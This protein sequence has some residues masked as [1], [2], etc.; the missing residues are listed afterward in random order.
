MDAR[1]DAARVA[2]EK[3]HESIP[4]ARRRLRSGGEHSRQAHARAVMLKR[5]FFERAPVTCA[6]ELVGC[7][8]RWGSL[9]G[10]IVETEAYAATGDPACHTFARPSARAFVE[11]HSAGDAYVYFNYG[12]HWLFNVLV[13]GPSG[14]GFVLIRA[15]EPTRGLKTMS[16]RRNGRTGHQLCSG[17]GKLCRAFGIDGSHHGL[18]LVQHASRSFATSATPVR[19]IAAAR[20]GISKAQ[21]LRWRFL[22][23]GNPHVSVPPVNLRRRKLGAG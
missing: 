22:I 13:K 12:M 15:I 18:N 10:I 7:T 17:P 1:L 9:A 21:E 4:Q 11:A 20:V 5:D 6:R 19:V 3:P 16:A 8:F 23:P 2:V 14:A